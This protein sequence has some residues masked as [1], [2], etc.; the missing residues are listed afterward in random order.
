MKK[1]LIAIAG[2]SIAAIATVLLAQTTDHS[3]HTTTLSDSPAAQA[4]A[5]VN[6]RMHAEMAI[7]FTG[8]P[9]VD[10][11]R[12]MIPHHQGAVE[13]AEVILKYGT[14]PDVRA[15][16]EGIIAAQDKEIAW[17]TEWL[18]KNGQ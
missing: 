4:F 11:I 2:L 8:N 3:T 18:A 13:M 14:D 10:F 7:E 5:E 16:A 12:G 6:A 17:M 1:S 9:D 15:L